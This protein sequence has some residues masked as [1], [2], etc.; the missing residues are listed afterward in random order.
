MNIKLSKDTNDLEQFSEYLKSKGHTVAGGE[1][2]KINGKWTAKE[3]DIL[4]ELWTD[5][6]IHNSATSLGRKG[7]QSKSEA[8]IKAVRENGKL[9]GRPRK[10]KPA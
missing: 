9:G 6:C 8:K 10:Q 4:A 7:G 5:Y 3:N 2:T 1:S